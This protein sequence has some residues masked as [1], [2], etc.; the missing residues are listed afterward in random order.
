[1]S[2]EVDVGISYESEEEYSYASLVVSDIIHL[3]V[4][5]MTI[6]FSLLSA[7]V[8]CCCPGMNA[9]MRSQM[10]NPNKII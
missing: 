7:G 2:E 5:V 6:V 1:M 3:I 4:D 9:D 10:E 8:L